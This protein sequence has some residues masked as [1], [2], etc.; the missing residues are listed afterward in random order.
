[1]NK[2][3]RMLTLTMGMRNF[4]LMSP[5]IAWS[6]KNATPMHLQTT[7]FSK[8]FYIHRKPYIISCNQLR[9][10]F[11]TPSPS[12]LNLPKDDDRKEGSQKLEPKNKAEEKGGSGVNAKKNHPPTKKKSSRQK[13]KRPLTSKFQLL[14]KSAT[15]FEVNSIPY[16][17]AFDLGFCLKLLK[18]FFPNF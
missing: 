13:Y 3:H 11:S 5:S 8:A 10:L 14:L 16:A 18:L 2:F 7:S 6:L 1:M 12:P 15:A 9:T 4:S 17:D